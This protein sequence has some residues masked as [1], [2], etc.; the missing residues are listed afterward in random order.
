MPPDVQNPGGQPGGT[1]I[2]GQQVPV[3][4]EPKWL[5]TIADETMREEAKKSYLLNDDYTKKTQALAEEKKG[6]ETERTKFAETEKNYNTM[7]TW[8]Q[9]DYLPFHARITPK[10]KEVDAYLKGEAALPANG[11]PTPPVNPQDPFDGYDLLSGSEQANKMAEH[12]KTSVFE[13]AI[14]Q[15]N[16]QWL[17]WATKKEQELFGLNQRYNAIQTDAYQIAL[18]EQKEGRVFPMQ[19]YIDKQLEIYNGKIDVPAL[20][21]QQVTGDHRQKDL[22]KQ[23]YEQGKKDQV[24]EHLNQQQNPGALQNSTV[25][26]FKQQPK[27]REEITATVQQQAIEK[28]ISW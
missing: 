9:T 23:W 7:N 25:P 24:Q 6:W 3:V 8:Y 21:F 17:E 28:G 27:T 26:I 14:K 5:A 19:D 4:E 15:N 20:A 11:T 16:Q 2:P 18:R 22:E 12:L 1:Q 13:P 10:W